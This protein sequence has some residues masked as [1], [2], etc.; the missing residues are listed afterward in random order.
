MVII[1][2]I[3]MS[4]IGITDISNKDIIKILNFERI[5]LYVIIVTRKVMS[6]IVVLYGRKLLRKRRRTPN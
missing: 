6:R 3:I 1:S 4:Q 2:K 5:V